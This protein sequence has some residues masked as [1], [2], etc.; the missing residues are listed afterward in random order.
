MVDGSLKIRTGLNNITAL[1]SDHRDLSIQKMN[2]KYL[3]KPFASVT[4]NI[5]G[6]LYPTLSIVN[7]LYII[8]I[9][10]IED[11]IGNNHEVDKEPGESEYGVLFIVQKSELELLQQRQNSLK[12][13][14]KL[15]KFTS[16]L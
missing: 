2:A 8:L 9:D 14:T 13:A 5:K 12:T 1:E 10:H 4:K 16:F 15:A 11:W 7:P 3:L 6:S